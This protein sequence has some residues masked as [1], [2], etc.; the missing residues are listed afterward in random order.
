[1]FRYSL[2]EVEFC[3]IASD[4]AKLRQIKEEVDRFLEEKELEVLGSS[5]ILL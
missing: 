3:V 5:S 4:S 1:M 2:I